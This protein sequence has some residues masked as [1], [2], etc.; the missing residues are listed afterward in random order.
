MEALQ[1]RHK[2][3]H[4]DLQ[5][6]ITQKKKAATKKTRKGINAECEVLE[7]DLKAKHVREVA[8]FNGDASGTQLSQ[9]NVQVD[10]FAETES[11]HISSEQVIEDPVLGGQSD[12]VTNGAG[13]GRKPHRQKA[14]LA[15]RAAAIEAQAIEAAKEAATVPD[16]RQQERQQIASSTLR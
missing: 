11:H 8:E 15:R 13:S 3:E 12:E 7:Q 4:R 2:K 14:R 10:A 9:A 1:A 16:L 5:S 6:R